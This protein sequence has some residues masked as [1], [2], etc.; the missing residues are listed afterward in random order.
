MNIRLDRQEV[1][2]AI[3]SWL[4]TRYGVNVSPE[5]IDYLGEEDQFQIEIDNVKPSPLRVGGVTR[6]QAD[7]SAN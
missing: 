7:P 4:A 6:T 2:Q 1:S 5:K 3:A